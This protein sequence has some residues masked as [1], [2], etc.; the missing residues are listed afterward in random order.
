MKNKYIYLIAQAHENPLEYIDAAFDTREKAQA[1]LDRYKDNE[2]EMFV[3]EVNPIYHRDNTSNCYYIELE[4]DHN[5]PLEVMISNNMESAKMAV[6]DEVFVN[7]DGGSSQTISI[8]LFAKSEEE[9]VEQ[10][11]IR[12]DKAI[13]RREW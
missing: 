11:L 7:H 9:A 10:A 12:R 6:N 1:Y 2:A 3:C 4:R 13:E 5:E 8:Y